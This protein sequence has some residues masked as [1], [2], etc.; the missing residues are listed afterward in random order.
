VFLPE[1]NNGTIHEVTF[2]DNTRTAQIEKPGPFPGAAV[3]MGAVNHFK[4]F[5]GPKD[6]DTLKRVEPSWNNW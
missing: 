2:S 1:N 6:Y 4:V 3:S 5:V